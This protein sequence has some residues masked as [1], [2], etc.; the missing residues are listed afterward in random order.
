MKNPKTNHNNRLG[1]NNEPSGKA[2]TAA[3]YRRRFGRGQEI[4][5][6]DANDLHALSR[7]GLWGLLVFLAFGVAAFM[8]QDFNLYH[9]FPERVLQVLG[10][11]PPAVMIHLA[12]ICYSFTIVVPVLIRMA[13][14]D[15]PVVGWR[16]LF[17]R[18]AFYF[19]YL[20]SMT[21]PENLLALVIIGIILYI[22]EQVGIWSYMYKLLRNAEVSG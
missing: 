15:K 14:G 7:K 17:C 3:V 6:L 9:S 5:Q 11:P 21:L 2:E 1:K 16:H 4:K 8:L 13:N 12:L 19:F 18:L 20:V 10:C 22:I